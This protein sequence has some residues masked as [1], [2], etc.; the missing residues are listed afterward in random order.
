MALYTGK[1]S[2]VVVRCG[3]VT[4]CVARK[5][6]RSMHRNNTQD[7]RVAGMTQKRFPFFRIRYK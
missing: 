1:R 7:P 5:S 6:I 4:T 2:Q 3:G